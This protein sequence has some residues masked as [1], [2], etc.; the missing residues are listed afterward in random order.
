MAVDKGALL[1]CLSRRWHILRH[2]L[3]DDEEG[4]QA[5]SELAGLL[6]ELMELLSVADADDEAFLES[7]AG[8]ADPDAYPFIKALAEKVHTH[9]GVGIAGKWRWKQAG[10]TYGGAKDRWVF[11]LD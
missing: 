6:D 2:G 4:I 11:D 1:G 3:P 9:P 5:A 7:L 10:N 8:V